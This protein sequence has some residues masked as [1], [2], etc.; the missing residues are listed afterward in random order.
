MT[1]TIGASCTACGVCLATCPAGALAPAPARPAVAD[2]LCTDCLACVEVCPVDA[3]RWV[4]G[5]PD[6]HG[7]WS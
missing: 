1:V 4:R 7:T 5:A 2:A 6:R 3:I